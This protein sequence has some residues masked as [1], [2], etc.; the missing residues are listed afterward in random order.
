MF[1]KP[2]SGG[3]LQDDK[4]LQRRRDRGPRSGRAVVRFEQVGKGGPEG[5]DRP[6]RRREVGGR[7]KGLLA[8]P[9]ARRQARVRSL[10]GGPDGKSNIVHQSSLF[11][12]MIE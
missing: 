5:A 10:R 2:T 4:E 6:R 1:I 12:E 11:I 8:R 9:R 7:P 3:A